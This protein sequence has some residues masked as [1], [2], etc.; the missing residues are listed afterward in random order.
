MPVREK[1]AL[2]LATNALRTLIGTIALGVLYFVAIL[3]GYNIGGVRLTQ[4]IA[5]LA[6][7]W[8]DF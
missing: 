3:I 8:C 1:A 2:K 7:G 4:A 5:E 6:R